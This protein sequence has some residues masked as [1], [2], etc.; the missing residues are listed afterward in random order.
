[1]AIAL[2][3]GNLVTPYVESGVSFL[4]SLVKG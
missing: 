3:T 4:V 2:M 1:M